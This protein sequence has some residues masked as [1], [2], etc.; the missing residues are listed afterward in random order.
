[1]QRHATAT[2]AI[3]G[4]DK[5]DF[6]DEQCLQIVMPPCRL[7]SECVQSS[8]GDSHGSTPACSNSLVLLTV[9]SLNKVPSVFVVVFASVPFDCTLTPT[10]PC[11][12][13]ACAFA[14]LAASI[15]RVGTG[16]AFAP[17]STICRALNLVSVS[18][19]LVPVPLPMPCVML[20]S[21][22]D[23]GASRLATFG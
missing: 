19:W 16:R 13:G 21:L 18:L 12:A 9:V 8:I 5:K 23:N 4:L 10:V 3:V 1:M 7:A 2:A 11:V 14:S 17:L 15:R 6:F 20:R 22:I